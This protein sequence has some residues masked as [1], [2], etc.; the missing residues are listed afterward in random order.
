MQHELLATAHDSCHMSRD[1]V[2]DTRVTLATDIT[3][4]PMI[5]PH[6]VSGKRMC[7]VQGSGQVP[8]SIF[9]GFL[10]VF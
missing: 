8:G 7:W 2:W 4:K 6:S 5:R 1:I 9:P 10:G 3:L